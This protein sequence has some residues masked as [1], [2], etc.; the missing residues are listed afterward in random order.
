MLSNEVQMGS[1]SG[2][3]ILTVDQ[4]ANRWMRSLGMDS[5]QR[6]CTPSYCQRILI[7]CEVMFRCT[8]EVINKEISSI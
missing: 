6:D 1:R 3:G 2:F 8:S 7:R 4:R 5:E